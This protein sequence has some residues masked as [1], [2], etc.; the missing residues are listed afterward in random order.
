MKTIFA[1]SLFCGFF[2]CASAQSFIVS[3]SDDGTLFTSG[4]TVDS[5]T[6]LVAPGEIEA[7]G[8]IHFG[9]FDASS[10][11]SIQL[12]INPY[13][14]PLR[15]SDIDVYGFDRAGPVLNAVDYN[16]GMYLG[17]W[18]VAGL[19]LG[20]ET[21]FDVTSFV[22]SVTGLYFGFELRSDGTDVFSS[23]AN[24]HGTPPEL[25]V[26]PEPTTLLLGLAGLS[27]LLFRKMARLRVARG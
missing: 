26:T 14:V 18:N 22:K 19:G 17:T 8:D 9:A 15:G 2:T 20:Q 23:T 21:Y 25:I 13:E 10:A 5:A 11:Q 1:A 16:R 4:A 7:V 24:N 12:E 6:V 27:G 3:P